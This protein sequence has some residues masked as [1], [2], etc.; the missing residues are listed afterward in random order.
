MTEAKAIAARIADIGPGKAFTA[1][2]FSDVAS[3]RN[4]GNVLGRLYA[5]G[6]LARA[7]RGVYYVPERSALLGTEVPIGVDEVVRAIARA[8]K[9]IVAPA[10]D[11]ALNA[12]GLD[13]RVPAKLSYVSSGPYKT[14]EYGSYVIEL[15]HRANRDLLDCSQINCIFVQAMKAIGKGN[16]SAETISVLA[17]NLSKEQVDTLVSESVGLTSWVGQA[18]KKVR[19]AKYGQ[20]C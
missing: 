14:Y 6:K 16:M 9:W 11:A 3:P 7:V 1:L 20:D 18:A 15:K 12:L 4:A 8:N 17:H 19:E 13:T 2:D 10:G 5:K